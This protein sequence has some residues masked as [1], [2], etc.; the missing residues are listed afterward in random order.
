MP[1]VAKIPA[2]WTFWAETLIGSARLGPVL[3]TAFNCTRLLSDF[4]T[5]EVTV[6]VVSSALDQERL[7]ALWTWKLWA[8][9]EGQ[10]YWCGVPSGIA[11]T[12][13]ATATLT[14]TELAGYLGR[15]QYDVHPSHRYTQV[16]QVAIA[17]D[18]AA[19]LTDVG[20]QIITSAGPGFPRDRTY[21]Y[22]EGESRLGLL[23]NLSAVI[24]GPQ[25]RSEYTVDTYGLPRASVRIAYPRVG[26]PTAGLGV[27]IPATG[28]DFSAAWDADALR[29]RTFA[30][31]VVTE[32][33][34]EGTPAPV[35]VEDR[36]QPDRPRLDAVDDYDGVTLIST[37]RER[38]ASAAT[39]NAQPALK[40][41]ATA[42]VNDPPLSA[43]GPG[44]DVTVR[45]VTPL[46]TGGIELTGQLTEVTVN[47]AESSAAWTVA[48]SMP[49]PQARQTL[50]ERLDRL[51]RIARAA[52]RRN[53]AP[54]P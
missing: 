33:A 27:V 12:G 46:L 20:V 34:P 8:Y 49:P 35:A 50:I 25:F 2:E 44:D 21:A 22:L 39:A 47:A 23:S 26:G 37:L 10:P 6:P 43:Y 17:A 7:L 32:D 31:G 52:F 40:L 3:P 16:E 19:P 5:G 29:T 9:Y 53:P 51:D 48:V 11:D 18:L 30:V 54:L 38:A 24:S 14:L 4:G 1:G 15:R 13:A 41:T 28:T 36:P 42:R 45:L